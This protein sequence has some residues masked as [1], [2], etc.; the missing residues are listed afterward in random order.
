M[1]GGSW[2]ASG[3]AGEALGSAEENPRFASG[4][5][6]FGPTWLLLLWGGA[7]FGAA[8]L[9]LEG[10]SGALSAGLLGLD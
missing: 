5:G 6:L 10:L 2:A 7:V 9:G 1:C 3:R 4:Q 8:G